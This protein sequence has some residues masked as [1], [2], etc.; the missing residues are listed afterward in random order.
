MTSRTEGSLRA[1]A[2]FSPERFLGIAGLHTL[3][4]LQLPRD[5]EVHGPKSAAKLS[6]MRRALR[7]TWIRAIALLTLKSFQTIA[8]ATKSVPAG[9][10]DLRPT[11]RLRIIA[12]LI[13][14]FDCFAS[15]LDPF[16]RTISGTRLGDP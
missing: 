10:E 12:K 5:R 7:S 9:T 14:L 15:L 6:A 3:P 2:T 11:D 16:S 4:A 13:F 8:F 1:G